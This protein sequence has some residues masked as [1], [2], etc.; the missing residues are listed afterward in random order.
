MTGNTLSR[1][2]KPRSGPGS[3]PG[4]NSGWGGRRIT[5]PD[6]A[7]TCYGWFLELAKYLNHSEFETLDGVDRQMLALGQ[8]IRRITFEHNMIIIEK[9]PNFDP[10]NVQAS[11]NVHRAST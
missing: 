10:S 3:Y 11:W 4:Y 8:Q 2:C 1:M 9:G 6:F 7:S 5:D